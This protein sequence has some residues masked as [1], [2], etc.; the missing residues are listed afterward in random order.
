M[1]YCVKCGCELV[2]R[3]ENCKNINIETKSRGC[4]RVL[5]AQSEARQ[6][7]LHCSNEECIHN[8]SRSPIAILDNDTGNIH[9][10]LR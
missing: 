2:G 9:Y 1:C 8:N 7:Y 4:L 6:V 10:V 3:D 5:H